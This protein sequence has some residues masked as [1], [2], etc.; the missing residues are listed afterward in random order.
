MSAVTQA[1]SNV[2]E[3]EARIS[4]YLDGQARGGDPVAA[5]DDL[6]HQSERVLEAWIVAHAGAPTAARKEG[7]RLLALH[8]QGAKGEASFHACR[9]TCRELVFHRNLV[10]A[11]PNHPE[12]GQRIRLAAMVAMH[13]YLFVTGKME[14][15]G[16]GEFCCSARP[17]RA[18][19]D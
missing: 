17:L 14:V 16:L 3:I 4:A 7:F 19:G 1:A 8:A 12:T 6:L 5:V 10:H 13:L 2:S 9:E 18:A 11:A 15:W